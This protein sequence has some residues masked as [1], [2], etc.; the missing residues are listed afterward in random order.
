MDALGL[1][2]DLVVEPRLSGW[3]LVVHGAPPPVPRRCGLVER[4]RARLTENV[5][6]GWFLYTL[7]QR[8]KIGGLREPWY[9]VEKDSATG[10]V[11]VVSA[12]PAGGASS[13]GRARV[14]LVAVL[15]SCT[16]WAAPGAQG[17]I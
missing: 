15:A 7:G 14:R 8:A 12:G 5:P 1:R 17:V 16:P 6:A 2:A 4:D 10:D 13:A 9:V 11:F 3:P